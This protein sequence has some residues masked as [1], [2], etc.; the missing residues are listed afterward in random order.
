MPQNACFRELFVSTGSG[1]S[2][3]PSINVL[4]MSSFMGA[5][6]VTEDNGRPFIPYCGS[7]LNANGIS[8]PDS[9]ANNQLF[10]SAFADLF[11]DCRTASINYVQDSLASPRINPENPFAG[12][13]YKKT[14]ADV[15]MYNRYLQ[16]CG[17]VFDFWTTANPLWTPLE[18]TDALNTLRNQIISNA[19]K[20]LYIPNGIYTFPVAGSLYVALTAWKA[21]SPA[22]NG[23][24]VIEFYQ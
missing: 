16:N 10:I 23:F 14:F 19:D 2:A 7:V 5:E 12:Y 9:I 13:L 22:F 24:L 18:Y 6:W 15:S 21:A 3:I 8:V 20:T 17:I 11:K 1:N 4:Q